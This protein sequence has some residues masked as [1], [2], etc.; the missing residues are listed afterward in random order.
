MNVAVAQS[1]TSIK[2]PELLRQPPSVSSTTALPNAQSTQVQLETWVREQYLVYGFGD[3]GLFKGYDRLKTH[4]KN[5]TPVSMRSR[6]IETLN[7]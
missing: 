6:A 2:N 3:H 4:L 1:P 7:G 5:V